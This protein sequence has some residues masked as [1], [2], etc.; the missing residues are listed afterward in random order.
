[1]KSVKHVSPNQTSETFFSSTGKLAKEVLDGN[2]LTDITRDTKNRLQ[3]I[4]LNDYISIGHGWSYTETGNIDNSYYWHHTASSTYSFKYNNEGQITKIEYLTDCDP[5]DV[6]FKVS[7]EKR[8]IDSHGNWT[9]RICRYQV[10]EYHNHFDESAHYGGNR[11]YSETERREI[12][13]YN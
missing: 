2:E 5:E 13:Y 12:S 10:I 4:E 8:A 7:I 1:M 3:C 11:E 9:E 6:R